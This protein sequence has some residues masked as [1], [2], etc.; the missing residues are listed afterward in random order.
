LHTFITPQLC[1][2][3]NNH[4]ST[5]VKQQ[6]HDTRVVDC[7]HASSSLFNSTCLLSAAPQ[8]PKEGGHS[9]DPLTHD[10]APP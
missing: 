3:S 5:R 7:G 9:H 10:H 1:P 8:T 4:T 6:Q 2:P